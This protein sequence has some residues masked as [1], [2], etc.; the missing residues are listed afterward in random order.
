MASLDEGFEIA[1]KKFQIKQF[2]T[3][4]KDAIRNILKV[5]K[6]VFLNLPTETSK[7][8]VPLTWRIIGLT[9]GH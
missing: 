2:N 3:H 7:D 5:K 1:A 8:S 6:D 4:Q 9:R